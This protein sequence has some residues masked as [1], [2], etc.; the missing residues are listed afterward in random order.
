[1]ASLDDVYIEKR[2]SSVANT[3]ESIQSL[4]LWALHHKAQHKQIVN[5]WLQLL[6]SA[7]LNLRLNLFYLCNEMVQT[8]KKRNADLFKDSF[9]GVL[10]EAVVFVRDS[11]VR[12]NIERIFR[13]WIERNV[14]EADYVDELMTILH[15]DQPKSPEAKLLAEFKP[16]KLLD[17]ITILT[18]ISQ[19]VEM[20]R[21]KS[22]EFISFSV[23]ET[24]GFQLRLRNHDI[25]EE[26]YSNSLEQMSRCLNEYIFS[27]D[28]ELTQRRL[29]LQLL[30]LSEMYYDDQYSDAL[31]VAQVI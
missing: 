20:K 12:S 16:E 21:K 22:L 8:C 23:D 25:S 3:Q 7:T 24:E 9:K 30:E 15:N 28:S 1:M 29:M 19:E 13:I 31:V 11:P 14:Y 10:G 17:A 2:L 18:R 4:S 27:L 6:K 5:S 26:E